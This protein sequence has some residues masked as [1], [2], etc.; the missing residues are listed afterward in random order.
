MKFPLMLVT[1]L[2]FYIVSCV[3]IEPPCK[4]IKTKYSFKSRVFIIDGFYR[5]HMGDVIDFGPARVWNTSGMKSKCEVAYTVLLE[6][7]I[8][9]KVLEH[10]LKHSRR[11]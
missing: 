2:S 7:N 1:L 8:S 11:L 3:A 10:Q 9:I 5:G 4:V 6:D